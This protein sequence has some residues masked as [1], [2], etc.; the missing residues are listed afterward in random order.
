LAGY[1]LPEKAK[2]EFEDINIEGCAC[3]AIS[4]L[5]IQWSNQIAAADK[6]K[7]NMASASSRL[8]VGAG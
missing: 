8:S 5:G 3:H 6:L 2:I 4:T 7:H 1:I